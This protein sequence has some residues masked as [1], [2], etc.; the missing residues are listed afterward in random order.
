MALSCLLGPGLWSP[1]HLGLSREEAP[2]DKDN[3]CHFDTITFGLRTLSHWYHIAYPL[4]FGD[5]YLLNLKGLGISVQLPCL[6]N[7]SKQFP[8]F[9]LLTGEEE[10]YRPS[11]A[12]QEHG[13]LMWV[14]RGRD[15]AKAC[16]AQEPVCTN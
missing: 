10:E 16:S 6:L 11:P 4:V 5:L 12:E 7:V 15:N 9:S 13:Q 8:M 3:I 2:S 14:L 1:G